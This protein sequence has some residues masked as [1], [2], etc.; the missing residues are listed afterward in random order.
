MPRLLADRLADSPAWNR[1]CDLANRWTEDGSVPAIALQCG[2]AAESIETI[3]FGRARLD[4]P[5]RKID[6]H[7]IFLVAS[8]T[9]PLVAMA[10][11]QLV[12]R[13]QLLLGTRACEIVPEFGRQ[14][15]YGITIRHLLTHSSGLPDMLPNNVE[16]RQQRAPLAEFVRGTCAVELEFPTGRNAAYSSMGFVLLGEI[17]ARLT[18]LAL[19]EFLAR[20]FFQPLGMRDTAL[21]APDDW[22]TGPKPTVDRFAEVRVPENMQSGTDW[23]WNSRYWRQLGA[24]WGGLLTTPADLGRYA[25]MLLGRGQLDGRRVLA[26][27]TIDIATRNQIELL[28]EIPEEVRRCKPWGLG[29]RLCWP[30]HSANFGD[31]LGPRAFGHWGATGTLLWIDPE[32]ARWCA[33]LTTQPQEP[34]GTY[35]ARLSNL[36]VAALSEAG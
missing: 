23:N 16:L 32:T 22:F 2:T 18:G 35:I 11:M 14:G 24:P 13:G 25:R 36:V 9:K 17:F 19:P 4:A 30:T 28:R 10:V 21:G 33:I 12:E 7:T 20:E 15:T 5:E 1:L 29:W 27:S 31:L 34:D 26:P 6:E 8:I 3:C